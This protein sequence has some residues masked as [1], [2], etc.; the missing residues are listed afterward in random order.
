MGNLPDIARTDIVD[1]EDGFFPL[2]DLKKKIP[3]M[4]D[5][6]LQIRL[7]LHQGAQLRKTGQCLALLSDFF[8]QLNLAGGVAKK[9]QA[10][11]TQG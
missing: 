9:K 7:L 1:Y 6:G 10:P 3:E 11:V 2:Q 8:Y 4:I 5:N